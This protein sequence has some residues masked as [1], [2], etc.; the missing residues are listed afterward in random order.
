MK[1]TELTLEQLSEVAGGAPH[2]TTWY[3]NKNP[4]RKPNIWTSGGTTSI[5]TSG[6]TTTLKNRFQKGGIFKAIEK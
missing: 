2:I 4:N 6:S 3:R 5:W 1:N